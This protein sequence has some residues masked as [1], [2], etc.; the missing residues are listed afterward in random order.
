MKQSN[1]ETPHTR[2]PLACN[3]DGVLCSKYFIMGSVWS[4]LDWDIFRVTNAST[5]LLMVKNSTFSQL[6]S[7]EWW[8][9]VG[10]IARLLPEQIAGTKYHLIRCKDLLE[11]NIL[12]YWW[13]STQNWP[14]IIFILNLAQHTRY[15]EPWILLWW[16]YLWGVGCW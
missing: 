3:C 14:I 6:Q 10:E 1:V 8:K 16:W 2:T 13:E 4:T 12:S 15:G 9:I 11:E 7:M 5:R